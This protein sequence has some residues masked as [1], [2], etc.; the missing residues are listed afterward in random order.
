[1][2][3]TVNRSAR[4][5]RWLCGRSRSN[6]L[7]RSTVDWLLYFNMDENCLLLLGWNRC[8]RWSHAQDRTTTSRTMRLSETHSGSMLLVAWPGAL[9]SLLFNVEHCMHLYV[10]AVCEFCPNF[11]SAD[12]CLLLWCC[13]AARERNNT[14]TRIIMLVNN[15]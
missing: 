10:N 13:G 11:G 8:G 1:M 2:A 4:A 3:V 6:L 7:V 9:F 14:R 15:L 5:Q 12:V